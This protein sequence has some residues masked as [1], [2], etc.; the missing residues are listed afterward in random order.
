MRDPGSSRKFWSDRNPKRILPLAHGKWKCI[1][2]PF[3][4]LLPRVLSRYNI[5]EDFYSTPAAWSYRL[6]PIP[7]HGYSGVFGGF[8]E[9]I[10]DK[11]RE[12]T[13]PSSST[14]KRYTY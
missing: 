10:R 4:P 11:Q 6:L 9:N 2:T 14:I 5:F 7:K 13:S 1:T 3:W 12:I 8:G